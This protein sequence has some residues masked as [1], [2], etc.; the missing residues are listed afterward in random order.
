MTKLKASN[1]IGALAKAAEL[2]R[3]F[4]CDFGHQCVTFAV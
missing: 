4:D 1:K 2:G 3:G